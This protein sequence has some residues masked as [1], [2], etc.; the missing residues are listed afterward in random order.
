MRLR[1]EALFTQWHEIAGKDLAQRTV[2]LK[3]RGKTLIVGVSSSAWAQ[4]V[5]FFKQNLLHKIRDHI[6]AGVVHD[7]RIQTVGDISQHQENPDW[8]GE[9]SGQE[10]GDGQPRFLE[11]DKGSKD[12]EDLLEKLSRIRAADERLKAWRTAEDWPLCRDCGEPVQPD[13]QSGDGCCPI[14]HRFRI[15]RKE[16]KAR[17]VLEEM[18]WLTDEGLGREVGLPASSCYSIRAEVIRFWQARIQEAVT[19]RQEG[20]EKCPSDF[21]R[22]VLQ[23]LMARYHHANPPMTRAVIQKEFGDEAAV[24]FFEIRAKQRSTNEG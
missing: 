3:L 23:L 10:T 8:E 18:P 1:H 17:Q 20:S 13:L 5:S 19:A 14:C 2:P 11:N 24:L 12:D 9:G 4:E 21:R 22:R 6:G 15:R 16:E 7:L